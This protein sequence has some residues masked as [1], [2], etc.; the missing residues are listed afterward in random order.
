MVDQPRDPYTIAQSIMAAVVAQFTAASV[1]LP[2]RQVIEAGGLPAWD[3]DQLTI[4]LQRIYAGLPGLEQGQPVVWQH[5]VFSAQLLVQL[6]RKAKGTLANAPRKQM[7]RV[8]DLEADAVAY[9]ADARLLAGGLH[10]W[11]KGQEQRSTKVGPVIAPEQQGE[12]LGLS[13]LVDV[14]LA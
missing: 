10:V 1:D 2:D 14:L 13:A 4:S 9:F 7:P 3:V 12:Y 11:R 5:G 6:V 8:Q